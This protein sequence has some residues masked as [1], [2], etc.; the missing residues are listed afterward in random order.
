MAAGCSIIGLADYLYKMEITP[1]LFDHIAHLARLQFSETEREPIRM[2]MQKMVSFVEKLNELDTTG[3][4]PLMH[5]SEV[6]QLPGKDIAI[7]GNTKEE[8]LRNAP[9]TD[10]N[11]FLV[12]KVIENPNES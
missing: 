3:I 5:M 4:A 7:N 8:G 2:E 10:G 12:P 6:E 11:Y 1:R 9:K